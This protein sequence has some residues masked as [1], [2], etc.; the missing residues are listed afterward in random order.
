MTRTTLPALLAAFALL[1]GGCASTDATSTTADAPTGTNRPADTAEPAPAES[2]PAEPAPAEEE[3]AQDGTATFG[4]TYTW[5]DGLAVTIGNPEPWT[6]P[7][8]WEPTAGESYLVF[9]VTLVNG[10]DATYEDYFM[11]TMQSGNTEAY[12]EIASEDGIEGPPMTP[13]LAGREAVFRILYRVTDPTDLV[14]S[15]T[16]G[17]DYESVIFTP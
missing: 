4:E 14:M 12:E 10:S 9:D 11:T 15:V 1:A 2:E 8:Y 16:P 5:E 13:L 17:F 6:A 3:P 7:D